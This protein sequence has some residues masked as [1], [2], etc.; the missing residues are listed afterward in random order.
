MKYRKQKMALSRKQLAKFLLRI[1]VTTALLL[2]VLHQVDLQQ[3]WQSAKT[4]KWQ[5]LIP[6]WA[7]AVLFLWVNS[8]KLQFILKKQDCPLATSTIFRASAITAL[9]TMILP[10]ILSSG[11]KWYILQRAT[12]KGS[13][14]LSSMLYNQ[15]SAILVGVVLGLAA[16]IVTNPTKLLL[17]AYAQH[18]WLLPVVCTILLGATIL[19]YL[20][21]LNGRTVGKII[22]ILGLLLKPFPQN[23]RQ[24]GEA[25]LTQIATFQTAGARF[26]LI[27]NGITIIGH[28]GISVLTCILASRA[29]GIAVPVT[30][31]VWLYCIVFLLGRLPISVANLGVREATLVGF[32]TLYGVEKSAA[33]LMSMILFSALVLMAII[34]ALYQVCLPASA[35][36]PT[37]PP[38]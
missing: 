12:G 2:W 35:S 16:L 21:L 37:Q 9:Y 32:L 3:F 5:F 17:P 14:V 4:V 34:G 1:L 31:L 6:V 24:K 33:L 11:I 10:G 26:H 38:G 7:L 19:I 18:R 22:T 15:L 23:V 25:L 27:V 28:F 29:A 20:L 8:I 36:K 13:R 30:V